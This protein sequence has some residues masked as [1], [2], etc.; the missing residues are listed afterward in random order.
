MP[1]TR[2]T[3][4]PFFFSLLSVGCGCSSLVL[5][6]VL[7]FSCYVLARQVLRRHLL[8][9]VRLP[10]RVR[11]VAPL[12]ARRQRRQGT[13]FSLPAARPCTRAPRLPSLLSLLAPFGAC[14][15]EVA[16]SMPCRAIVR[17]QERYIAAPVP[18]GVSAS[19]LGEHTLWVLHA[20]L[21]CECAAAGVLSTVRDIAPGQ[22]VWQPACFE[23]TKVR[24]TT[25]G[26]AGPMG[27]RAPFDIFWSTRNTLLAYSIVCALA[28]AI[29]STI[30]RLH[31]RP[32]NVSQRKVMGTS[33]HRGLLLCM[34]PSQVRRVSSW[35]P[36]FYLHRLL[37]ITP[38]YVFSLLI[39]WK[40]CLCCLHCCGPRLQLRLRACPR[41][42]LSEIGFT[43]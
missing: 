43:P 14:L 6:L 5:N 32:L 11:D 13:H 12:Q 34:P 2:Q 27:D 4:G 22:F 29:L 17:P 9:R 25:L 18:C 8:F 7:H 19:P 15:L 36:F 39:W 24:H 31:E 1:C 20:A 28:R 37:R 3:R 35:L 38:P 30:T 21:R 33:R 10:G 16:S 23:G 41:P 40:V 26:C 42:V